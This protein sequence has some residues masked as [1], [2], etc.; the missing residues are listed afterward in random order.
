VPG[1]AWTS[2]PKSLRH[3]MFHVASREPATTA[4]PYAHTDYAQRSGVEFTYSRRASASKRISV[5]HL[6][7]IIWLRSDQH[8]IT[9]TTS[10]NDCIKLAFS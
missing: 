9:A 6:S 7:V 1:A 5:L 3:G 8:E 4:P 10:C 2:R